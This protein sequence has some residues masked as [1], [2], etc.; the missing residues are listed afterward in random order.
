MTNSDKNTKPEKPKE[1]TEPKEPKEP[2]EPKEP[3]EPTEP[4]EPRDNTI[5][6]DTIQM[7]KKASNCCLSCVKCSWRTILNCI[8]GL[9]D[10][11]IV[12]C[13]CTKACLERIDC[14]DDE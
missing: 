3:K 7:K 9:M 14:D 5:Q 1:P 6:V 12:C 11:T 13:T 8:E 4:K 2:E 10:C